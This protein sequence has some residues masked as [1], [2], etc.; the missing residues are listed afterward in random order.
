MR[1]RFFSPP[2]PR[3][4]PRRP[5]PIWTSGCAAHI[6]Q[7]RPARGRPGDRRLVLEPLVVD[8]S[9]QHHAPLDNVHADRA[10]QVAEIG[11]DQ[12]VGQGHLDGGVADRFL[13]RALLRDGHAGRG[14]GANGG[15][16]AAAQG[17]HQTQAQTQY[18]QRGWWR[19]ASRTK[20]ARFRG[21]TS[22]LVEPPTT[23]AWWGN[24]STSRWQG[25]PPKS[26]WPASFAIENRPWMETAS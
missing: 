12:L 8:D 13:D 15:A 22:W 3:G 18:D 21:F 25:F 6:M 9:R 2:S 7:A 20:R 10:E 23:R 5:F 16:N 4:K 14:A 24:I 19:H 17:R 1:S 11:L 26:I